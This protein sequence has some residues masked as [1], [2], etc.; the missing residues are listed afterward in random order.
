MDEMENKLGSIL[1]N[2]EMM[3]KIMALAQSF[4][5]PENPPPPQQSE[6][7][8]QAESIPGLDINTIAK[9]SGL[10]QR[11]GVDKNQQGLLRALTPY[12]TQTRIQK[13]ERA[14]RAAKMA[15][16]ASS[17]FGN[18]LFSFGR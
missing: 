15:S 3:S 14:M 4:E 9:L 18:S 7:P 12:L 17:L 5:Q 16:M 13:L 1:G 10:M 8:P 11:T 2:P 6:P